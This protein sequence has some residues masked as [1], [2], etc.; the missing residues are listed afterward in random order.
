MI[1]SKIIDILVCP[2]SK[3][4]LHFNKAKSELICKT[5]RLSYKIENDIPVML[6]EKARTVS[7]EELEE[8]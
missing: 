1:N 5:C 2:Q 7:R 6:V 4:K 8:L 3:T